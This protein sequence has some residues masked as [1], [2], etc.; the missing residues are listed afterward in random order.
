MKYKVTLEYAV[1]CLRY[2]FFIKSPYSISKYAA[3][4]NTGLLASQ[5]WVVLDLNNIQT[6]ETLTKL[7]YLLVNVQLH[8]YDSH[9]SFYVFFCSI[10]GDQDGI[11][12][13]YYN[14]FTFG[15]KKCH[16]YQCEFSDNIT[17]PLIIF[18]Q[19]VLKNFK[20]YVFAIKLYFII[21]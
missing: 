14:S 7:I 15:G 10:E 5:G 3:F 21:N 11:F 16:Y 2:S 20:T 13:Q 4:S 18:I 17:Y 1:A 8:Y 19:I 9:L 12:H 6:H